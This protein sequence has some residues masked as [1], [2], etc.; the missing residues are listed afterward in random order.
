MAISKYTTPFQVTAPTSNVDIQFLDNTLG[1]VQADINQGYLQVSKALQQYNSLDLIRPEDIEYRNRKVEALTEQLNGY[2]NVNL[3]DPK[4]VARLEMEASSLAQ[5]PELISKVNSTKNYRRLVD[6]YAKMKENPKM[7]PWYSYINESL[8]MEQAGKWASGQDK[9]LSISSPT[10]YTD[11][12]KINKDALSKVKPT[13]STTIDGMYLIENE[14]VSE[15][16]LKSMTSSTILGNANVQ[17]QMQRNAQFVFKDQPE[18]VIRA[19]A[20]E[21]RQQEIDA[22]K[23]S[24]EKYQTRLK[25]ASISKVERANIQSRIDQIAGVKDGNGNIVME[26][27][28]QRAQ[29]D[30]DSVGNVPLSDLKFQIYAKNYVDSVVKPFVVDN[31]KITSNQVALYLDKATRD[32]NRESLRMAITERNN[33]IKRQD[34]INAR[35]LSSKTQLNK[36]G[37]DIDE[38]LFRTTGETK[39]VPLNSNGVGGNFLSLPVTQRDDEIDVY[40]EVSA[41]SNQYKSAN[42]QLAAQATREILMD[43]DRDLLSKIN[44]LLESDKPDIFKDGKFLGNAKGLAPA[45]IE[46]LKQ[47]D[48]LLDDSVDPEKIKDN[49]LLPKYG[50]YYNKMVEN[51]MAWTA[52]DQERSNGIKAVYDEAKKNGEFKGTWDQFQN[53]LKGEVVAYDKNNDPKEILARS[54]RINPTSDFLSPEFQASKDIRFIKKINEKLRAS[55]QTNAFHTARV[56]NPGDKTYNDADC[57]NCKYGMVKDIV[58]NK[59]GIEIN[60]VTHS[61]NG[62]ILGGRAYGGNFDNVSKVQVDKI[63]P[64]TNQIEVTLFRKENPEDKISVETKGRVTLTPEEMTNIAGMNSDNLIKDNFAST[65]R[66]GK[67]EDQFGNAKFFNLNGD[68]P[69]MIGNV[70]YRLWSLDSDKSLAL[71]LRIPVNGKLQEINV[72]TSQG[73]FENLQQAKAAV[74]KMYNDTY[75]MIESKYPTVSKEE[76]S[77]LVLESI[78]NQYD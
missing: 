21:F 67:M 29:K 57:A 45:Q 3:A 71:S 61:I 26:G 12:D 2:G 32:D 15:Q 20:A 44:P 22:T 40:T 73:K 63:I 70:Q 66:N 75:Q 33:Q 46:M 78:Y 1:H 36:T 39:I 24:I 50:G 31:Q 28:L 51:Q 6:R 49:P 37:Y 56:I 34:D 9:S 52:L 25:D 55:P 42:R 7:M 64:G 59:T 38:S 48:A 17:A 58:F 30:L 14:S 41:K 5:D 18:S 69:G 16:D 65:L 47:Y 43:V 23:Q 76:K 10:L 11:I 68:V 54:K 27:E 8:D 4:E 19:K 62:N 13:K 72:P 60:G 77:K 74:V 53:I 35:I